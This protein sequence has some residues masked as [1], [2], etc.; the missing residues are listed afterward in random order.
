MVAVQAALIIFSTHIVT[1]INNAA[2]ATEVIGIVGLA[3]LLLLL[4]I[5]GSDGSFHNLTSTGIVSSHG[6]YGWLGPV[7]LATLL[8]AYT[9]VGFETA[10]NMAEETIE[11]RK[12][13]PTAMWRA[14]LLSGVIGL[15]F[16]IAVTAAMPVGKIAALSASATPVADIIKIQLGSV[17][18]KIFLLF[19]CVSIFACGLIIYVSQS[20]LI[21]SMS[22]DERFPGYQLFSRVHPATRTPVN[23]VLLG[24]VVAVVLQL[25]FSSHLLDLF[26]ASTQLP[27]LY[28][29]ATVLLYL[30]TRSK[31]KA[32]P[33]FF[34]LGRWEPLVVAG[35]LAWLVYELIVVFAPSDF[36]HAA[37]YTGAMSGIG[38]VWIGA[39]ALFHKRA[40]R[41]VPLRV[42][43]EA[44]LAAEGAA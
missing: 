44:E 39:L 30:A 26:T 6:W 9:I 29:T 22:R 40:L 33:G 2:V 21:W 31:L 15:V 16:L 10:S 19:V 11:P 4:A 23:A 24:F 1:M 13:V 43:D 5:F 17:L 8:G 3:V 42:H 34:S 27:A 41:S 18:E 14:V 28:Y 37:I 12:V 38:V 32:E 25:W 7:M 20:R 36:H 35:A